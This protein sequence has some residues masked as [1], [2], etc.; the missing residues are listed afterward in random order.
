MRGQYN[1]CLWEVEKWKQELSVVITRLSHDKQHVENLTNRELCPANV[2]KTLENLGW[3]QED[4]DSN[5]W[6]HDTWYTFSN[7]NY[8]F[9]LTFYYEGYTF[10]MKL[11]RSDVNDEEEFYDGLQRSYYEASARTL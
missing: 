5:G 9:N 1:M 4:M 11:Y 6:Q 8:H 7:P 3:T 10:E 2:C